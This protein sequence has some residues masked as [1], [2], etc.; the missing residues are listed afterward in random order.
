M[1]RMVCVTTRGRRCTSAIVIAMI[2]AAVAPARVVASTT[3]TPPPPAGTPIQLTRDLTVTAVGDLV[4]GS[5]PYGLPSD[6]G[7]SLFTRVKPLLVGDIVMANLE[8]TLASSGRSKCGPSSGP[9]CFAFRTPSSYAQWLP[10]AGIDVV[11]VANNHI[12]DFGLIG[13]RQTRANLNRVGVRHTGWPG[14][15]AYMQTAGGTVAVIGFG[16]ERKN[17]NTILN[18]PAARA[19]VAEAAAH[20]GVVI[21]TMHSGAEG[22]TAQ[23]LTFRREIF[24]GENRG[25][26]TA[27]ARAMVDAGA[28]LVVGHGPHVMRAMELYK[29]RLIAYS[30]GNFMGYAVF[31]ISGVSG[32]SGV[33]SVTLA[34]DGHLV[35]GKLR[36]IRLVGRGVPVPGGTSVAKVRALT[37]QD[38]GGRGARI[39]ADG[40]I[41]GAPTP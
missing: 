37:A 28:D 23:H 22:R 8:G 17:Q 13:R 16:F 19:L 36:P 2:V 32:Q 38:L 39:A 31:N 20:A 5:R 1:A 26:P 6:G 34:P 10:K 30:M 41:A 35:G 12:D 11:N 29:G 33:L 21:V 18:L 25:N 27:F 3:V 7:R 9:H 14:S 15:I 40:S 4:M 24:L